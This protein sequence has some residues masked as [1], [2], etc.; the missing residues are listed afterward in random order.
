MYDYFVEDNRSFYECCTRED[1]TFPNPEDEKYYND[2][3]QVQR[4]V[5]AEIFDL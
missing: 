5:E 4:A 2:R 3:L 1:G